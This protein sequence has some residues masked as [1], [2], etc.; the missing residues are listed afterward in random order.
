VALQIKAAV[1]N[2]CNRCVIDNNGNTL[3]R[4][5]LPRQPV[6]SE[7]GDEADSKPAHAKPA[8]AAPRIVLESIVCA[9]RPVI[10]S[11]THHTRAPTAQLK[12]FCLAEASLIETLLTDRAEL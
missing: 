4:I 5:R 7:V 2:T 6:Q 12:F 1:S 11:L 8:Y 3:T 10:A 9:T